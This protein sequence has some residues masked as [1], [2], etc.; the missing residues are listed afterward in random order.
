M[1]QIYKNVA[2][3]WNNRKTAIISQ[4]DENGALR[5]YTQYFAINLN[6]FMNPYLR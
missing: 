3:N 1:S 4:K 2:F 6:R 5:D